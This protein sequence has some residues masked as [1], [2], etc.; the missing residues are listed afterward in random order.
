MRALDPDIAISAL[1]TVTIIIN[2]ELASSRII[3]GLFVGFAVLALALAAGGLL[4][5]DL[6]FG[7]PAAARNRHPAGAWRGPPPSAA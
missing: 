7:R 1:K 3:N 5:R 4:R 6:L 2:E